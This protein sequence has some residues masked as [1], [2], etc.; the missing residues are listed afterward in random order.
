MIKFDKEALLKEIGSWYG[1][2]SIKD[3]RYIINNDLEEF[4]YDS[5]DEGLKDW[6]DTL[7]VDI[8]TDWSKEI[9][10]IECLT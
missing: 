8:D 5:V 2:F 6:L 7:K 10:F 3:K 9:E 4:V 1:S